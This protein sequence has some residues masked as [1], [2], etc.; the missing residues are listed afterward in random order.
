MA[1]GPHDQQARLF[2]LRSTLEIGADPA[3][4]RLDFHC[5]RAGAMTLQVTRQSRNRGLLD[6]LVR[7]GCQNDDLAR[8]HDERHGVVDGTRGGLPAIP[9]DSEP[10]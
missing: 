6:R 7:T 1:I 9:G 3:P 2:R 8:L 10:I 5:T 4:G